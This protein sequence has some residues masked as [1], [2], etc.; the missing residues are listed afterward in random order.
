MMLGLR[1]YV[2]KNGFPGVV[3]GLSG[4]IDSAISAAVAA[5]ALGAGARARRHAAQPL[6]LPSTAWRT[7]PPARDMLGITYET[8]PISGAMEAFAAALAPAFAGQQRRTSP[9]K[10]S[11]PARAA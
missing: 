3:L 6:H 7:P 9:R 5:D 11:S 10:T 2:N 8:I 4:G 1:D